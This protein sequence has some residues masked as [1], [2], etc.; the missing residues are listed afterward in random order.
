MAEGIC[1]PWSD[2]EDGFTTE[3]SIYGE[4]DVDA[5]LANGRPT[6]SFSAWRRGDVTEHGIASSSGITVPVSDARSKEGLFRDVGKFLERERE[7]LLAASRVSG[8][9][10]R[11]L[12][13]SITLRQGD[14]PAGL[15]FPAELLAAAGQQDVSWALMAFPPY[16]TDGS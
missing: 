4:V 13:T 16:S 11:G 6:G 1:T 10:Q 5:L 8:L 2:P 12:V 7:F 9:L 14:L 3:Y 15:E